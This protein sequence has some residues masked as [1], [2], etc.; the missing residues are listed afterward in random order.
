MVFRPSRKQILSIG[1][2]CIVI[3]CLLLLPASAAGMDIQMV[4]SGDRVF[5]NSDWAWVGSTGDISALPEVSCGQEILSGAYSTNILAR[6]SEVQAVQALQTGEGKMQF[7]SGLDL[8]GGKSIL[9][10]EISL[11]DVG[12]GACVG[13]TCCEDITTPNYAE[14]AHTS[15][16]FMGNKL[17]Y[18]SISNVAQ[19]DPMIPDSMKVTA[20][21]QGSGTISFGAE[22]FSKVGI[23]NTS[24]LGLEDAMSSRISSHG[25]DIEGG[26]S[27]EFS[28][29]MKPFRVVVV[30]EES[31]E[32]ATG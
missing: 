24:A 13:D 4:A 26:I 25:K 1:F 9:R 19:G 8:V 6:D 18:Q 3:A 20:F 17:D 21:G 22:G 11:Y 28:S 10:E 15:A 5:L 2:G 7:A 12:I 27:F 16:T 31:P 14:F 32:E 30:E 29:F 23:G